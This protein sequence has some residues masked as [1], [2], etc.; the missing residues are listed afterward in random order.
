MLSQGRKYGLALNLAHQNLGQLS[1]EVREAI[2]ANSHTKITFRTE[3]SDARVMARSFE[4]L[5]AADDLQALGAY[6]VAV[7]QT[8]H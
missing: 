5:L 1:A 8:A 7:L 3:P 2:I 6:E 4:P